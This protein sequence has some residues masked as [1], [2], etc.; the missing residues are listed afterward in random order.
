VSNILSEEVWGR[1]SSRV[2]FCLTQNL[3]FVKSKVR[4]LFHY[5]WGL[6][7]TVTSSVVSPWCLVSNI[8]VR[9]GRESRGLG[10]LSNPKFRVLLRKVSLSSLFLGFDFD[11]CFGRVS[12]WCPCVEYFV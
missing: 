5:F 11:G 3:G 2:R 9:F 1:E 10:F 6:I 4:A 7:L 8:F 12:P